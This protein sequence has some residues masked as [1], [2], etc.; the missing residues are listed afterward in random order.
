MNSPTG[1]VLAPSTGGDGLPPGVAG[2]AALVS[3]AR[4]AATVAAL[5]GAGFEGRRVGTAGGAGA[6]AWLVEHLTELGAEA[7]VDGFEVAGYGAAANVH[8]AL[9]ESAPGGVDL[10][11]TAHYDGVG[12]RGGLHRPG[13]SDNASGVAMVLEA[14]RRLRDRLPAG[15]GLAVALLDAEEV[16][17]LGSARHAAQLIAEGR[18]PLVLNVDGAG[19]LDGAVSVEAGGPARPLLAAL[20]AVGRALGVPLR[21]GQ[22]ASDSRRY[23]GSGLGAVGLGAGMPGYH[24][25][26]DTPANVD[27]A[28]LT[29]VAR[30]VVA[31]VQTL[32]GE[33]DLERLRREEGLEHE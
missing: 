11:L 27:P 26:H 1:T 29:A 9:R 32:A 19:R 7:Y 3:A 20:D 28:T 33:A 16:G 31:S 15:A 6:R 30:L 17:A 12:D 10:L 13:A 8:G 4:M 18:S 25:E 23:A 2:I 14:A 24:T 21:G 5:A 22:V